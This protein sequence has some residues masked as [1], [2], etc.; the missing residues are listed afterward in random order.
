MEVPDTRQQAD[1]TGWG[2][3][4]ALG[5]A[6]IIS[7]GSLYYA[8]SF[9]IEPLQAAAGASKSTVVGAFSLGLLI[10]GLLTVPVGALIDRA[11]GRGVMTAG[12]LAGA[13]LLVLLSTTH[14]VLVLYIAWV[15][16][17]AAMAATLY[18]P[19]F[20]VLTA[21]FRANYRRAIA[22]L[23]LFGGFASTVFWPLT[24]FL[25]AQL[26][27]RDALLVLAAFNALICAPLH[28]WV[29][30][31]R[32][33]PTVVQ[34]ASEPVTGHFR[35]ALRTPMFYL[36]TLSFVGNILV[37]SAVSVHLM[38]MLQAK[39]LTTAHAALVG[40]MVGPMQVAGRVLEITFG[41]RLSPR[42]VGVIAM[43]LLPSSLLVLLMADTNAWLLLLFALLYGAGNGVMT[44]VRGAI[45]AE[46]FGR[47]AYGAIN[48]AM[49]APVLVAKA[50]GP[51]IAALALTALGDYDRTLM[52]LFVIG[53]AAV[54]V[55][56]LA[57][58]LRRT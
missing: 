49:A 33:A 43:A 17:G 6:Q 32:A 51:L 58:T 36:L 44:I 55:F 34:S 1:P 11:G 20:A 56:A 40:A 53:V 41:A 23:T 42:A 50:A 25:I 14:S 52:M 39:G 16:L 2:V 45:A 3:I 30:P 4:T 28:W 29:V 8:F 5:I 35:A 21:M 9:L 54:A 48:G 27:W 10:A 26:G 57:M 18:D 31:A 24:E 47:E 22:A 7:W 12:S 37:F 15:G 38:L 13:G 19:A 46:V